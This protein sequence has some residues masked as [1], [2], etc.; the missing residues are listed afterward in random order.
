MS[1]SQKKYLTR[2]DVNRLDYACE[3]VKDRKIV[4]ELAKTGKRRREVLDDL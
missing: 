4:S 3:S 2:D 1:K